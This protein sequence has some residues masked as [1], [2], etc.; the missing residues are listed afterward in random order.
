ME[1]REMLE[2]YTQ[3]MGELS[4][5]DTI[6][7][8]RTKLFDFEYPIFDP[9]YKSVLE[10]KFIRKFYTREIGFETEGLFKFQLETWLLINM[11]Y[12]NKL[13]ESELI[14]YDPLVNSKMDTTV[15]NTKDKNEKVDATKNNTSDR[16][17]SQDTNGTRTDTSF[18]RNLENNTPDS[19]LAITTADGKGVI[20]YASNITED[21]LNRNSTD[22]LNVSG[23]SK[24][25]N[26]STGNTTTDITETESYVQSKTGKVGPVS[27][28]KMMNE[29]RDSLIRIENQM[30]NEMQQ[31][32]MLVY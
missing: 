14:K 18:N 16:T 20:E 28:S 25:I 6:E 13:F 12:F 1:L 15:T 10:T 2:G 26:S 9:T 24:D 22:N 8:G 30:F 29:Y 27:Y 23:S 19:R 7:K 32:F 17:N 4:I 3:D 11:P 21:A 31:L 5:R